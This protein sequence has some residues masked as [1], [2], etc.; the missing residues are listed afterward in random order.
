MGGFMVLCV[1]ASLFSS[2]DVFQVVLIITH[3]SF[4]QSI[5]CFFFKILI[6]FGINRDFTVKPELID[7][8]KFSNYQSMI[9]KPQIFDFSDVAQNTA[10]LQR[11]LGSHRTRT[12][13][14]HC[15][16]SIIIVYQR[17]STTFSTC[18]NKNI[19]SAN[20]LTQVLCSTKSP[21]IKIEKLTFGCL[22]NTCFSQIINLFGN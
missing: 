3:Q 2:N 22:Q 20:K 18:S 15:L 4:T 11:D 5:Q 17:P 13:Y 8:I 7:I 10:L 21:I 9:I 6:D 14:K 19:R 1:N 16:Y 12:T